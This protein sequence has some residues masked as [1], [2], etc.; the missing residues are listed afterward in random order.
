MI[1]HPRRVMKLLYL[2]IAGSTLLAICAIHTERFGFYRDDS[3]Y[4]VM[5]K[6]LATDSGYRI[7]SLPG[8]PMQTKSPPFYPFL[9]SLIWRAT[10]DFP[11]NIAWLTVFSVIAAACLTGAMWRYLIKHRYA[12]QWLA[13]ITIG[14][15]AINWRTVILASGV[16]SEILYSLLAVGALYAAE[17]YEERP[18][19]WI[20]GTAAGLLAG[21]TLLTRSV[22]IALLLA[23]AG[24]YAVRRF[25]RGLLPI[26]IG[27]VTL[28]GWLAWGYAHAGGSGN[29]NAGSYE[30]YLNTFGEL[31][32]GSQGVGW[33]AKARIIA[34][35]IGANAIGLL[36]LSTPL[37]CLG[38]GYQA[39][40]HRELVFVFV[41]C[42]ILWLIAGG[43]AKQMRVRFRL[44]HAYVLCYIAVHL[45]WPY[46]AYDRFIMPVLPFLILFGVIHANELLLIGRKAFGPNEKLSVRMSG[47]VIMILPAVAAAISVYGYATGMYRSIQSRTAGKIVSTEDTEA[48]D[49]IRNNTQPSDVVICYRDPL[50]YLFTGRKAARSTL[51]RE[52]G[53]FEEQMGIDKRSEALFRIVEDNGAKYLVATVSDFGLESRPELQRDEMKEIV[54]Q[55]P[56]V[57]VSVFQASD[58]RSEVYRISDG[59]LRAKP[60]P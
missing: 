15:A 32:S 41:A 13:L 35:I 57:F 58:G 23:M 21:L 40:E 46:T 19:S 52:G 48:I 55:N 50:Y 12:T 10:P 8:E 37:V 27:T 42:G 22:G 59:A 38:L 56:A 49:W 20:S 45:I 2:S 26:A 31:I 29:V 17:E 5:A 16:Y 47:A 39:I 24:Y 30:S 43:F 4:V 34:E 53:L 7:L 25:K 6:A 11:A 1:E 33:A 51:S 18:D 3:M 44:M 60:P 54:R 9:L 28:V 14:L 36:L